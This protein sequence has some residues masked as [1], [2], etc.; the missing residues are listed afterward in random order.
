MKEDA[1][2]AEDIKTDKEIHKKRIEI[3][4]H[5]VG[6]FRE[7]IPPARKVLVK[8]GQKVNKGEKLGFIE[9]MRIMKEVTSPAKGIVTAKFVKHGSPV[10]YGQK[11]LEVEIV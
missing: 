4:S 8:I 1:G 3:A 10:E 6:I 2:D 9:S 11:I 5:A 7:Y